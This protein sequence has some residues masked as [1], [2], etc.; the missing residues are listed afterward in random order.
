MLF[1]VLILLIS[2]CSAC[3]SLVCDN[4]GVVLKLLWTALLILLLNFFWAILNSFLLL[5]Y[6]RDIVI[7]LLGALFYLLFHGLLLNDNLPSSPVFLLWLLLA[8]CILHLWCHRRIC[9]LRLLFCPVMLVFSGF[10]L[11]FFFHRCFFNW[12]RFP[13]APLKVHAREGVWLKHLVCRLIDGVAQAL[14][15]AHLQNHDQRVVR[16]RILGL[17]LIFCDVLVVCVIFVPLGLGL[18]RLLFFLLEQLLQKQILV[19][20]LRLYDGG[21][22]AFAVHWTGSN[23]INAQI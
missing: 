12:A 20:R 5:N 2:I 8:L 7:L 1:N 13:N 23:T 4:Y 17:E 9:L 18:A 14:V 10:C 22:R 3:L 15:G 21:T 19:V 11:L 6:V 16:R